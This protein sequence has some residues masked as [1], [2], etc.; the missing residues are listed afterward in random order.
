M[1]VSGFLAITRHRSPF[2]NYRRS[3][4]RVTPGASG[5]VLIPRPSSGLTATF[6]RY[7]GRRFSKPSPTG[8]GCRGAAGEGRH[9]VAPAGAPSEPL[10]PGSVREPI[11]KQTFEEEVGD[12][13][14]RR[15]RI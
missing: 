4:K 3:S 5:R 10:N 6:S 13:G 11:G 12:I 14:G 2:F 9:H 15:G 7:T 8:R 1:A